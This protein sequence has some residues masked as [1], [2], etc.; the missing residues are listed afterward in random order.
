MLCSHRGLVYPSHR[1]PGGL[2][3]AGPRGWESTIGGNWERP[4]RE[5]PWGGGGRCPEADLP[6]DKAHRTE[7]LSF[8]SGKWHPGLCP[9]GRGTPATH[10]RALPSLRLTHP[11]PETSFSLWQNAKKQSPVT[12]GGNLLK[13]LI[14]Q[15]G[16]AG[17]HSTLPQCP[18][19]GQFL[20]GQPH[21]MHLLPVLP[22]PGGAGGPQPL[23]PSFPRRSV[24]P[25]R[26]CGGADGRC[27]VPIT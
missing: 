3:A 6:V 20:G 22:W 27:T 19:G 12:E 23:L 24:R 9:A 7:E 4:G 11:S 13:V 17:L 26:Q 25:G 8:S 14:G 2:Q 16:R 10:T 15:Q 21:P 18:P 5:G 1:E